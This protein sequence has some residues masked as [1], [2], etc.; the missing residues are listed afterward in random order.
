MPEEKIKGDN[1][2]RGTP[3][4]TFPNRKKSALLLRTYT[5]LVKLRVSN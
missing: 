3:P 4:E 2:L 1:V 5:L